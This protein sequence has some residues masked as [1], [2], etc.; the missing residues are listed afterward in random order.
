MVLWLLSGLLGWIPEDAGLWAVAGVA[1]VA[2]AR[3]AGVFRLP[4]PQNTRQVPQ[5]VFD[6]GLSRAALRFGFELGLGFRT[7]V[8]ATAPYALGAVL[9]LMHP[10]ASAAALAGAGFGLG[11]AAMPCLR[12]ASQRGDAWDARLARYGRWFLV[13]GS[14]SVG[15]AAVGWIVI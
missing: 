13:C 11:R 8:P 3:D 10:H 12:L 15:V 2:V 4:L 14:A 7:Y 1:G 9:L 6:R 5:R